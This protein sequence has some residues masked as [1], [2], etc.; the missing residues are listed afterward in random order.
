VPVVFTHS[1]DVAKFVAAA[2]DLPVWE[3]TWWII[4]DR[5]TWNDLAKQA[6]EVKGKYLTIL[7]VE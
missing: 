7:H 3:K 4:D 5:I 1:F 2:L 6:Q